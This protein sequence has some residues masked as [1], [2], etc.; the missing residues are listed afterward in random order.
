MQCFYRVYRMMFFRRKELRCCFEVFLTR[1]KGHG[2][3]ARHMTHISKAWY[4][5]N[6]SVWLC[7]Q[8]EWGDLKKT[9]ATAFQGSL[10]K[11]QCDFLSYWALTWNFLFLFL[12]SW[13]FSL[14]FFLFFTTAYILSLLQPCSFFAKKKNACE[15][16]L[17]KVRVAC[18]WFFFQGYS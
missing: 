10:I 12:L 9:C 1:S 14:L 5:C 2:K 13:F 18:V 4:V 11:W 17:M 7:E 6:D 8:A 3:V 15:I 16:I